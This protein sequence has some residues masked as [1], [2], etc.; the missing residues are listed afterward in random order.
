MRALAD[1]ADGHR[2]AGKRAQTKPPLYGPGH[3]GSA[4]APIEPAHP[5]VAHC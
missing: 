4:P 1:L 2:P 3:G 5:T